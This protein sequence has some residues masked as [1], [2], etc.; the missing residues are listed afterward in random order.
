MAK[1][2]TPEEMAYLDGG[3]I[4][5]RLADYVIGEVYARHPFVM[6]GKV[7][8]AMIRTVDGWIVGP[9]GVLLKPSAA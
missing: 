4:R 5:L 8:D 9:K 3:V 2:F 6:R 7:G 1:N